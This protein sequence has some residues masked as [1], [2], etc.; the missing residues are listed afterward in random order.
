[1]AVLIDTNFLVAAASPKDAHHLS[2]RRAMQTLVDTR[3]VPAPVL[4]EMFYM[5]T[6]RVSYKTA[7]QM[8]KIIRTGAFQIETLTVD[9]MTRMQEIMTQYVDNEF[10]Y[11]DTAIMAISERLNISEIYTFDRR[12]F[13]VFIPTHCDYLELLP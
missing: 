2:A 10:D 6:Q 12:D 8:F 13:S 11:V 3:I 7:S 4:P 9:D 5:L 1:M